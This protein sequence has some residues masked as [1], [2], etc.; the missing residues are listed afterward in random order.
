M[1]KTQLQ[2]F[3]NGEYVASKGNDFFDLV[4]PVTGEVYAQSPN[5]TEAEVD[6]AYTAA[7][8]AFKIWGRSTPS[9]R[10]KALLNLADAIEANADRLIEAQSRNT[11]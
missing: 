11:G 10:Q 9:T 4:S 5:A 7:K 8:E 2:H 1:A 3:I 6:A